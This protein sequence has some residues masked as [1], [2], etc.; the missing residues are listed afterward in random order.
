VSFWLPRDR[1]VEQWSAAIE[2]RAV[3]A[4]A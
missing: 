4:P 1:Q 2:A 3:T